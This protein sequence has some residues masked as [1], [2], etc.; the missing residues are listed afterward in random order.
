MDYVIIPYGLN[1]TIT[2][3]TEDIDKHIVLTFAKNEDNYIIEFVEHY[4]KLGF[5]KIVI[6]DNND[7]SDNPT[8]PIILK[9][10]I[11]NGTVELFDFRGEKN[12]T[13]EIYKIY[14]LDYGYFKWCGVFDCDEFLELNIY[15][16]NIKDFLET[17]NENSVSFQWLNFGSN[18]ND[19]YENKPL[20]ERF[21]K[22]VYPI[23]YFKENLFFKS[24]VRGRDK[25][26][27]KYYWEGASSYGV[28]VPC[29]SEDTDKNIY[30]LGGELILYNSSHQYFPLYYRHG[31]IRHYYCKSKEEFDKKVKRGYNDRTEEGGMKKSYE[32]FNNGQE[33]NFISY[34]HLPFDNNNENLIDNETLNTYVKDSNVYCIDIFDEEFYT[35]F[36]KIF[37]IMHLYHNKTIILKPNKKIDN[38]LYTILLEG[39]LC[40]GNKLILPKTNEEFNIA[41]LNNT[42]CEYYNIVTFHNSY[43]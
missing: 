35:I 11:Q 3:H 17:I 13:L 5:D 7:E 2:I 19:F 21:V 43:K 40:T 42:N 39:A 41:L 36:K 9:E 10:Y 37:D 12:A 8:M 25:D 24:I 1:K 4:L 38:I 6:I 29:F 26:T 15:N 14:I 23:L 33:L 18:D 34:I 16:N 32:I 22:P 30:N 20:K 27:L 31:F 28:H